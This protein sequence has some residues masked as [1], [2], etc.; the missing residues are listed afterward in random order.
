MQ[1]SLDGLSGIIQFNKSQNFDEFNH[2]FYLGLS[3]SDL[4]L[5][6]MNTAYPQI[7]FNNLELFK[8]VKGAEILPPNAHIAYLNTLIPDGETDLL[9]GIVIANKI[10]KRNKPKKIWIPVLAGF[11]AVLLCIIGV[12]WFLV[13]GVTREVRDLTDYLNSP[14]VLSEKAELAKLNDEISRAVTAYDEALLQIAEKEAMPLLTREL[15]ETIVRTGRDAVT[16]NSFTFNDEQGTVRVSASAATEFSASR[17]VEQLRAVSMIEY[18]EYLGY[19]YDSAGAF[20]FS[21]EVKAYD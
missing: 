8:G 2:C 16:V 21:I 17:Y 1:N 5:V 13:Y 18:I 12:L 15:I 6:R 9:Q 3:D 19:A 7:Q 20:N 4:D 10:I 11:V 14:Q